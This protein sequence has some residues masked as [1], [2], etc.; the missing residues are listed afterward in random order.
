MFGSEAGDLYI[1]FISHS[2]R[3]AL[4]RAS[5]SVRPIAYV[6]SVTCALLWSLV[7]A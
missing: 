6:E 7:R 2:R 5:T 3:Q 4:K 1:I